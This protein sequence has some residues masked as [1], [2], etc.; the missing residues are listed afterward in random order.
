MVFSLAKSVIFVSVKPTTMAKTN[1]TEQKMLTLPFGSEFSPSQ[2]ELPELLEICEANAGN[3]DAIEKAV[4]KKFFPTKTNFVDKLGMNCRLGLQCY[5]IIDDDG[6]FTEIGKQ[7]YD[8]RKKKD[9]YWVFAKHILLNLNGM[10]FVQVMLSKQAAGE[11]LTLANMKKA[12]EERGLTYPNG[13]KHPSI[14]RLWLDKVGLTTKQWTVDTD[15]LKQILGTEDKSSVLA[16]LDVLQVTFLKALINSGITEP[17][18]ASNVVKLA[19]ATYGVTFPEKSLPKLVLN[20][21]VDSK[22]IIATKTTSGRG[23]KPF[24]VQLHP[25]ANPEVIIPTLAQ[26]KKR[27]DPKLIALI[28]KPLSDILVD[29]KSKDTYVSGLALEALSFKLMNL[30]GMDYMAT[31]L[32]GEQTGGAEVDLLFESSRLVYSRWQ[33][34]CKNT[35]S[36]SLDPVA[37]EVGLTHFLKSNVIIV[38]TTGSFSSEARKYSNAIMRDS[39]LAIILLD[40]EDIKKISKNPVAIVDILNRD[41]KQTMEIKRIEL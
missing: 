28:K 30:L 32:R 3:C 37:K 34:Q 31:R 21:L 41:A 10:L 12:V 24:L 35:K 19:S 14:M 9:L 16:E 33:I 7:L 1:K 4:I 13:G 27:L 18:P 2:I 29:I 22:L 20:K 39:N 8:I 11:R 36:V 38:V 26:L 40:G 6:N 15:V 23:A 25:E 5:K 17:Q